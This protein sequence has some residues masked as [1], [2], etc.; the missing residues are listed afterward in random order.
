MIQ[1]TIQ[2]YED[3]QEIQM[4]ELS[5]HAQSGKYGQDIVC[6]AVSVLVIGTINNLERLGLIQEDQVQADELEGGYLKLELPEG[7]SESCQL[8]VDCLIHSLIEIQ[9]EYDS[10]ISINF[11]YD[12]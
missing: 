6:A 11:L 9:I 7:Q 8:L 12:Y 10:F 3:T 2:T 5:G 4:I 1:V